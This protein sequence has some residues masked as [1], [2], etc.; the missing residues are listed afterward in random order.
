VAVP[1]AHRRLD[2]SRDRDGLDG[3]AE[4]VRWGDPAQQGLWTKEE[5]HT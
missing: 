1:G 4:Q 2:W 3:Q 5:T